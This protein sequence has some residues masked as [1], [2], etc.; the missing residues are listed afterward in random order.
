M[1]AAEKGRKGGQKTA[2]GRKGGTV[3][4]QARMTGQGFDTGKV[5][6]SLE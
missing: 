3:G 2:A 4:T 6:T 5:T 1:T